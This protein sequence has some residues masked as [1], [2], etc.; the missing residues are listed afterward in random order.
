MAKKGNRSWVYMVPE[1]KSLP[2][3]RIQTERNK[4]NLKE[5]LRLRLFHPHPSVRKHVWFKETAVTK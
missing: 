2:E 5:K 1:D 4:V 3:I